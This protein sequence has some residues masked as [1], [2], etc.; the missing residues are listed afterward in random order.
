MS[1]CAHPATVCAQPHACMR[2]CVDCKLLDPLSTHLTGISSP[3]AVDLIHFVVFLFLL[4]P[5]LLSS[6]VPPSL[7][8]QCPP[9][10]RHHHH[11]LLLLQQQKQQ[12]PE[13][14]HSKQTRCVWAKGGQAGTVRKGWAPSIP[15]LSQKPWPRSRTHPVA[16][17]CACDSGGR[18]LCGGVCACV[19][20]TSWCGS[21]RLS[22]SLH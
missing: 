12:R 4:L 14:R 18:R 20:V 1:N 5:L 11:H 21:P 17:V 19:C 8:W 6:K 16:R 10:L 3:R 7:P 22:E 2:V 15:S 13:L 9:H